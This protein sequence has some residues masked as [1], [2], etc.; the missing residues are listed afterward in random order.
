MTD[1]RF[2]QSLSEKQQQEVRSLLKPMHFEAGQDIV[3]E[4][5]Q[6]DNLYLIEQG[7]VEVLKGE[8]EF[9][10]TTLA[11]GQDFG[12]MALLSND[13]RSATVRAAEPT[14][15]LALSVEDL[16]ALSRG[17][18]DSIYLILMRNQLEE[19]NRHLRDTSEKTVEALKNELDTTKKQLAMGSFL[20]YIVFVMCMYGFFLRDS[21]TLVG[22]VGSST[23]V[24]SG[25]LVFYILLLFT[26]MKRSGYALEIYG[27]TL[28]RW[29]WVILDA[30][31]WTAVF[32]I[33]LSLLKWV[34]TLTIPALK[35]QPVL[36]MKGFTEFGLA[37][38]LII[39]GMYALFAP[40]QEFVARGALQGSLQFFLAGK[41]VKTKAIAF[42]TLM[43]CATHLH[44]SSTFALLVVVP[45][46]F[47]G[48]L[49]A[50]QGS[51][52]GVS[53]SHVLIGLWTLFVLGLPGLS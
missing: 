35:G 12:A 6:G 19:Q 3:L 46:V 28:R 7:K 49:F 32:I 47:W 24:T 34:G 5:T 33:A 50:R 4:G 42:S 30:L 48:I 20:G 51:L 36:S 23:F 43:F 41:F 31:L 17:I 44:L 21:V 9:R 14:D 52:I 8:N 11:T 39:F 53:I 1:Y 18:E 37:K 26:M 27:L 10:L 22:A 13:P 40:T 45:S 15:V 2:L 16:K 29:K 38:S 25:I